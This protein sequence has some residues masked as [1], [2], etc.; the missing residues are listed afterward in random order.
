MIPPKKLSDVN[1]VALY[2]KNKKTG[3][4]H[5]RFFPKCSDCGK[6]LFNIAEANLAV[7]DG[8]ARRLK[9]IGTYGDL[10]ISCQT[11]QAL[12]FCWECDAKQEQNNVPWQNALGTFRGLDEPQRFPEPVRK[13]EA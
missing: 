1:L 13:G 9:R 4:D 10:E 2:I 12:V 8:G 5:M 7:V 6:I 11:G 3:C